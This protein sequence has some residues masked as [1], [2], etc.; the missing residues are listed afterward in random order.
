M[1]N[2]QE[3][4]IWGQNSAEA[5]AMHFTTTPTHSCSRLKWVA[6]G[7]VAGT[8]PSEGLP[9][10]GRAGLPGK[11]AGVADGLGAA[12]SK[13]VPSDLGLA[14]RA[15]GEQLQTNSTLG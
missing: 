2:S 12:A 3:G 13:A 5:L 4:T 15:E 14:S 6:G 8:F 10:P 1:W 9:A 7:E 11:L